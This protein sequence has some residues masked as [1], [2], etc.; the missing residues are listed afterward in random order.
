MKKLRAKI[1]WF[2]VIGIFSLILGML[3]Y[4]LFREN[5]IITT[6]ISY[7]MDLKPIRNMFSWAESNF[8]KFYFVDFLWALSLSCWL[9]IIFKPKINVSL[10]CSLVVI[11]LGTT[12]E[13]LQFFYVINGTGDILDVICYIL[14]AL[15]VNVINLKVG[16][17]K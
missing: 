15:T 13:L 3:I 5:T 10:I 16:D 8:L 1:L 2:W 11:T 9:H 17:L 7:I 4:L 6:Q 12:F 14:A